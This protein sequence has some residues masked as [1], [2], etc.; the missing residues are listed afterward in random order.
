MKKLILMIAVVLMAFTAPFAQSRQHADQATRDR[1]ARA[2]DRATVHNRDT[3]VSTSYQGS[4]RYRSQ[5]RIHRMR[6][7][8]HHRNY[9]NQ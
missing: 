2:R 5:S 3:R 1:D 9:Q 6:T 7:R 4:H 8:R